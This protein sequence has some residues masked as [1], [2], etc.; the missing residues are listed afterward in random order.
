MVCGITYLLSAPAF[1]KLRE[2]HHIDGTTFMAKAHG[3]QHLNWIQ[4]QDGEILK[5]N[6]QTKD[7]EYAKIEHNSLKASGI[8][9]VKSNSKR[10]RSL[11]HINKLFMQD[12]Q[13]L[14]KLKHQE[15]RKKKGINVF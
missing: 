13:K 4:T 7:F 15:A 9:Y 11:G 3:N 1:S 14:W 8:R 10:A 12:L 6:E 2:F 5:Y